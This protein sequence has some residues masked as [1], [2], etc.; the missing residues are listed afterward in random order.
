MA[1]KRG[2]GGGDIPTNDNYSGGEYRSS[3]DVRTGL[4]QRAKGT[5]PVQ[6]AVV[7]GLAI[8]EGDI[9][10][11]TAA[12]VQNET[13][14]L[15][16][17][18][19][20]ASAVVI[21][22][23]QFRW[24]NCIVPFTI[25]PALPNQAR[26]TDAI[27]HWEATTNYRFP[28]K[29]SVHTDWI[30]FR[31]AGGCSSHVGRQGGQQFINLSNA[32]ST[33]NT[34][35][36]IGHAIGLW[37]E[38]SRQDRDLFVN[39]IWAKIDPALAHNFNQHITDGDDVGPYDYGSIMHYPRTAFSIDGSDTIVPINPAGAMI[40]QRNALSPGDIAAANSLCTP[41]VTTKKELTSDPITKKE[42][43]KDVRLDTKKEVIHDT[44]KE[45]IKDKFKDVSFDPIKRVG[46]DPP[47]TKPGGR[48][49]NPAI[50]RRP[51]EAV[52][53]AVAAPH[54]APG[55]ENEETINAIGQ[56]DAQLQQIADALNETEMQ[57]D[58]LQQQYDET[59][60][61]LNQHLDSADP[62]G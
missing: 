35:H 38:Q 62:Q 58:S 51:G 26:V 40:G 42:L 3:G 46:L 1:G 16:N 8:F 24:P 47:F 17:P 61:L 39:I 59:L 18:E 32:C 5:I 53:F 43:V 21:V 27:A 55:A 22:G 33:G 10:L 60:A 4:I 49:I 25:D 14:V 30:T 34:I 54:Q 50:I 57:R 2:Q 44:R 52:P 48:V 45:F 28:A 13:E 41:V 7:D 56:L 11:G 9:V 37:H 20:F 31:P 15:R 12:E 6:Y 36:E 19:G 29:T 23:A